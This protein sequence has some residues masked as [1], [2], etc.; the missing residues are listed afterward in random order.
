MQY[1]LETVRGV[2][3]GSAPGNP[4]A[5]SGISENVVYS[6]EGISGRSKESARF[7]R[8]IADR[9]LLEP[10]TI[11]PTNLRKF[12]KGMM[13]RGNNHLFYLQS[14]PVFRITRPFQ[15]WS[16][17]RT[18]DCY[19]RVLWIDHPGSPLVEADQIT[20]LGRVSIPTC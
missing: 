17:R 9:L 20:E 19:S 16:V 11:P 6:E 12:L 2:L 14:V 18:D 13:V 10:N 8:G 4:A 3:N 15:F 1:F 7:L 5:R